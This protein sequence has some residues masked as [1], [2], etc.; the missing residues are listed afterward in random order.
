MILTDTGPPVALIDR[1]ERAHSRCTAVL[2]SARLPLVTTWP[3][4]TEAMYLLG[5]IGW[6]AQDALWR[7][8]L[9]GDVESAALQGDGLRRLHALI[10]QYR[11]TPIDL[12]D[13][14]LIALAEERGFTRIFTLD[15]HF[16]AYRIHG[17]RRLEVIP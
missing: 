11:D 2:A 16:H 15:A 10:E 13:A 17:R 5:G 1:D 6:R 12:A 4:F 7:L 9:R 8:A 14:S 3:V